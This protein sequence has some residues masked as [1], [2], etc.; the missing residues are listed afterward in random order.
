MLCNNQQPVLNQISVNLRVAVD[1][2]SEAV[3]KFGGV[4]HE[5]TS[6]CRL[7]LAFHVVSRGEENN[8]LVNNGGTQHLNLEVLLVQY[9]SV[10]PLHPVFTTH[11]RHSDV[12][13]AAGL[14]QNWCRCRIPLSKL[15]S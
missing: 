11:V 4:R 14:A 3:M 12:S 1:Q 8:G 15:A 9:H 6:E 13:A 10:H 2:V 5:P 7:T